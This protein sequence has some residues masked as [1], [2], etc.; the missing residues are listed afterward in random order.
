[1]I[2][3]E[4]NEKCDIWSIGVIAFILL[5][6]R[7]PFDGKDNDE[8]FKRI[9]QGHYS[10]STPEWKGVSHDAIDLVKKLLTFDPHKRISAE[11]ALKHFWI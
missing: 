9:K 10:L 3:N 5:S 1:L 2:T 7:P 8:I 4:L 11:Q 6:G